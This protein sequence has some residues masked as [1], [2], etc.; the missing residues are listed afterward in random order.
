[1]TAFAGGLVAH[2]LKLPVLLGIITA[3]IL[4]PFASDNIEGLAE[5]GL[6]LLLFSVGLE[7]S[8]EKLAR[9]GKVAILGSILQMLFVTFI[10]VIFLTLFKFPPVPA[11]ILSLGFSLSSTA[12]VVKILGDRGE[13]E[14]LQGQI[15]VGWCLVQDL[16]VIPMVVLIPNLT[17][18]SVSL[19]HL[20]QSFLSILVIMGVVFFAARF[21]IIYFSRFVASFNSR[22]LL[23]LGSV[24]L[25]LGIALIVSLFGVSPALGAFLAGVVIARTQESH[26]VFAETRPLR[27]LFSIL[28]FVSLGF[29]VHPSFLISHI[30]EIL[31]LALFVLVLK[32]L[33]V[34]MIINILGVRGKTAVAVA[35]G[36]SQIGEFSFILFLLGKKLSI[37]SNDLTDIGIAT[38]LVTLF[39]APLLFKVIV[40]VWR[41]GKKSPLK[42]LFA[43]GVKTYMDTAISVD[44]VIICGYGRM[45]KWIGKTLTDLKIPFVVVD[46]NQ[47]V[48]REAKKA[49][50]PAI[51]GDPVEFEVL[52][53]AG[54]KN[55]K[56]VIISLPDRLAQNE[57][58]A[59]CQTAVPGVKVI[60]RA[61]LDEDVKKLMQLKVK[62]VVQPEFE[63]AVAV[64]KDI[65]MSSGRTASDIKSI[66]KSL[67]LSHS[68]EK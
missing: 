42:K 36:L 44:H 56:I 18:Q 35:L 10:S 2:V 66:I 4:S 14:S 6:I 45:G 52:E 32:I 63:G 46:Y 67:R 58:I 24:V 15:M 5:I 48:I 57:I 1:M 12:L 31:A 23:L 39:A 26:A 40:S 43:G 29:L 34:F 47:K 20:V 54:I 68:L 50:I 3:G 64:V 21:L 27:D 25:A 59:Y 28:F 33:V 13:T 30:F 41:W 60:V 37:L 51:F 17:G 8:L 19:A 61:H 22:E 11:L 55:A 53:A 62:R 38:A 49:G 65:L 7:T 9:V 16:A